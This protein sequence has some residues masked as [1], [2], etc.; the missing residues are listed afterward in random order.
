MNN[1]IKPKNINGVYFRFSLKKSPTSPTG[2]E[3]FCMGE[4][5]D[6]EGIPHTKIFSTP[7]KETFREGDGYIMKVEPN[8]T[9]ERGGSW[10]L[11]FYNGKQLLMLAE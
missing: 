7:I 11:T 9:F 10:M 6:E 4:G 1:L 5:V 3:L 8:L 2:T